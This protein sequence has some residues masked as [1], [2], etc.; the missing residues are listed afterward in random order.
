M[1]LHEAAE[2]LACSYATVWRLVTNSELPAFRVFGDLRIL[3]SELDE[4]IARRSVAPAAGKS[5]RKPKR[6]AAG[7]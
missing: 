1:T 3:H 2:Y 6:R 5:V 7:R 4:W